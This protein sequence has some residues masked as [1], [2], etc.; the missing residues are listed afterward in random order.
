MTNIIK[1]TSEGKSTVYI[2]ASTINAITATEEGNTK[3]FYT[4]GGT[5]KEYITQ[6]PLQEVLE[7]I[8]HPVG[9]SNP[10]KI[11]EA[12]A[13]EIALKSAEIAIQALPDKVKGCTHREVQQKFIERYKLG[14]IELTKE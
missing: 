2:N 13:H 7:R 9:K 10:Y 5:V 3:V 8:T 4:I 12:E 14:L 1:L 6:E 11:S